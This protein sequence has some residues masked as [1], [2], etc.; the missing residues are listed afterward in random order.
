MNDKCGRT[1]VAEL[2]KVGWPTA[3]YAFATGLFG[4]TLLWYPE[5]CGPS[6]S[7]GNVCW[8]YTCSWSYCLIA[9]KLKCNASL[10]EVPPE[11]T[12]AKEKYNAGDE[13]DCNC[14]IWDPDCT[15]AT[16]ATV[17]CPYSDDVCI[18]PGDK[19]LRRENALARRKELFAAKG[20][21]THHPRYEPT[22]GRYA[23]M[24][25]SVPVPG[26]WTCPAKYYASNDGCDC[27]CGVWDPD[28]N[29]GTQKVVNCE[30]YKEVVNQL[31]LSKS[32]DKP[33]LKKWTCIA[34]RGECFSSDN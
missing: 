6:T 18:H 23:D 20:I 11:W 27:N 31:Q 14:G 22:F 25:M 3:T 19:C 2:S 7:V 9:D 8:R 4:C 12:C 30:D 28:C 29:D 1:G 10:P 15:D 21:E 26:N 5:D 34:P 33:Q 16:R 17:G 32:D 13:C 24:R